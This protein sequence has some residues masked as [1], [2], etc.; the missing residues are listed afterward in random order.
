MT[1]HVETETLSLVVSDNH[2]SKCLHVNA[3]QTNHNFAGFPSL[4]KA[5]FYLSHCTLLVSNKLSEINNYPMKAKKIM[6]IRKV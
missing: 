5:D 2:L 1:K 4:A 3:L 6:K